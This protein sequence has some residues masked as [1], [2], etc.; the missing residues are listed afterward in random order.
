MRFSVTTTEA[1][2]TEEDMTMIRQDLTRRPRRRGM[3]LVELMIAMSISASLLSAVAVAVDACFRGYR[4]NQE[5]AILMQRSRVAQN[6]IC[7]SIRTTKE[8]A[9]LSASQKLAFDSG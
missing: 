5:Q 4:I 7:T 6:F 3:G 9:P 2:S 8:H 1:A